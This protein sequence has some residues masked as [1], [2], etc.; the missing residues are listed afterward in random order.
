M[1]LC[2]VVCSSAAACVSLLFLLAAPLVQMSNASWPRCA[3]LA[4]FW[5][6]SIVVRETSCALWPLF[7]FVPS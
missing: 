2:E 3:A 1:T 5:H 4:C 6:S 7:V